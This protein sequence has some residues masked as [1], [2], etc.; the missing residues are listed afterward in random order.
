MHLSQG[1][2]RVSSAG[3]LNSVRTKQRLSGA[4]LPTNRAISIY[5]TLP[6]AS[7]GY[8]QVRIRHLDILPAPDAGEEYRASVFAVCPDHLADMAGK[9]ACVCLYAVLRSKGPLG[10]R[11]SH[12]DHTVTLAGL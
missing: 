4:Q 3:A 1:A 5:S 6:L 9:G 2:P 12:L 7:S 11:I 10:V 8:P